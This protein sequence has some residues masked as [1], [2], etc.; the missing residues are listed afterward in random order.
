[1][2]LSKSLLLCHLGPLPKQ[3]ALEHLSNNTRLVKK[4]TYTKTGLYRMLT[5]AERK[6]SLG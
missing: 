4:E 5:Y 1:M 2:A 3:G 6:M